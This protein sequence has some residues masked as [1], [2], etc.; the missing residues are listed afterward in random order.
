M[1]VPTWE[2][3]LSKTQYLYEVY[4]L[5]ILIGHVVVSK[6]K[7][8]RMTYGDTLLRNALDAMKF[9]TA[10]NNIFMS[11]NTSPAD[12]ETRRRYLQNA[13]SLVDSIS[14]ISQIFLGLHVNTDGCSQER[15]E[16]EMENIGAQTYKA[17]N[18]IK[19]VLES[20]KKVFKGTKKIKTEENDEEE[21]ETPKK[22][23]VKK[24]TK[25]E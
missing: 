4:N 25:E 1:S 10:A 9:A 14:T 2:R 21:K 12:Y 6:P 5:N 3:D 17:H 16:K 8:Y 13:M 22:K 18:L 15:L 19:G 7:K 23:A 20:D 24:K 11:E